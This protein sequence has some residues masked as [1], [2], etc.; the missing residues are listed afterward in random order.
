MQ[1]NPDITLLYILGIFTFAMLVMRILIFKPILK[2]LARR[3]ELTQE[4]KAQ[5]L[6]LQEKT[7]SMVADYEGH[8]KEARK[9]G[10]HEKTKLTQEGEAKANQL[11]SAARQ[12]LESQLQVHRQ[13]LQAQAGEA[14]QNLR[15]QAKD[16]SQQMAEKL[17]GRKVGV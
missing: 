14:S 6:S 17:L 15:V 11:L 8:L 13:N 2:V 7:E 10:L 12:E 9:Q 1:I 5:A 3:Q 16:L 4:A